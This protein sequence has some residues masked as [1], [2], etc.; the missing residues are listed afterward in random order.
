MATTS[1]AGTSDSGWQL[2]PDM[3]DSL[4]YRVKRPPTSHIYEVIEYRVWD[5]IV[6]V[7]GS[8]TDPERKPRAGGIMGQKGGHS[9]IGAYSWQFCQLLS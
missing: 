2:R 9:T 7:H 5:M 8:V 4:L 3:I 1:F 6:H